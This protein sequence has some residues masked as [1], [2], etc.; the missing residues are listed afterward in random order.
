MP[1]KTIELTSPCFTFK[2][3]STASTTIEKHVFVNKGTLA[4]FKSNS[5][6]VCPSPTIKFIYKMKICS[7]STLISNTTYRFA[8]KKSTYKQ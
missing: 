7:M 8:S 6:T 5:G 4:D 2:C 3:V 1:H